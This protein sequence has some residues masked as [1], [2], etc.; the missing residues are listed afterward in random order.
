MKVIVCQSCGKVIKPE[1][2]QSEGDEKGPYC[3]N[4]SDKFG[5]RKRFSNIINDSTEF[6]AKHLGV[7]D[8]EAK[9]MAVENLSKIP[10]NI[11]ESIFVILV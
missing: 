1:N 11:F 2:T 9:K 5:H 8:I 10:F 7:S 3:Q 4:C 6:L